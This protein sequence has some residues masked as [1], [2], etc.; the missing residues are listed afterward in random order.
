[1]HT[2]R[3]AKDDAEEKEQSQT[4]SVVELKDETLIWPMKPAG[5]WLEAGHR[6]RECPGGDDAMLKDADI[7]LE[8]ANTCCNHVTYAYV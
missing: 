1:M 7:V 5:Q 3:I 4:F 8:W 6:S 2:A